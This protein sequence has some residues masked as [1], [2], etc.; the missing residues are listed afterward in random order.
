M[1]LSPKVPENY[2]FNFPI[3]TVGEKKTKNLKNRD[4]RDFRDFKKVYYFS[5][6]SWSYIVGCRGASQLVDSLLGITPGNKANKL[7]ESLSY[8]LGIIRTHIIFIVTHSLRV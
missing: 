3:D 6:N 5:M 4:F 7:K 2:I 1:D 8:P